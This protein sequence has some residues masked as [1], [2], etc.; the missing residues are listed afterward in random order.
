MLGRRPVPL[1]ERFWNH[2]VK[3]EGCWVWVGNTNH[4]G[5]GLVR[6]GNGVRLWK[7][8]HRV[9]W[10]LQHGSIPDDQCVLHTCDNPPCVRYDHLFL[11]DRDTNAKD[12]Q[13][14]GRTL[15]GHTARSR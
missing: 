8:A 6:P 12:R 11:G 5:Y 2:V 9:A 10:E 3:T 4:D 7:K 13:K 1:E 15:N 14:K